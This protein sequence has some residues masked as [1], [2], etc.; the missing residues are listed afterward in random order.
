MLMMLT[1]VHL[2]CSAGNVFDSAA[3]FESLVILTD[4][5]DSVVAVLLVILVVVFCIVVALLVLA[6]VLIV[7]A[8]ILIVE[9]ARTEIA[10]ANCYCYFASFFNYKLTAKCR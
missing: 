4:D 1:L 9:T 10:G 6:H 7:V 8:A 3:T 2:A 5:A